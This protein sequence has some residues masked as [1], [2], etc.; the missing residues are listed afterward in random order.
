[1]SKNKAIGRDGI[2]DTFL[3]LTKNTELLRNL[4][5]NYILD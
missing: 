3:K 5:N 4:W 2:S 1:M